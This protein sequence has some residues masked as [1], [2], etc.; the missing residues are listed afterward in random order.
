MKIRT[1]VMVMKDGKAWG[2]V[3]ADG[4]STSYGWIEP[5]YAPIHDPEFCKSPEDVTY[6]GS[7]DVTELRSGKLVPVERRIEVMLTGTPD[8]KPTDQTQRDTA[9]EA[10]LEAI[11]VHFVDPLDPPEPSKKLN[12]AYQAFVSLVKNVSPAAFELSEA[13]LF[14]QAIAMAAVVYHEG[15]LDRDKWFEE[16]G[17]DSKR[18]F[19]QLELLVGLYDK[20]DEI[21]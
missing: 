10:C 8:R 9:I 21:K 5:E 2:I 15:G 6:P 7:L 1:G 20:R 18:M 17:A 12:I 11:R 4:H 13:A 16:L 14:V 3:D 19:W